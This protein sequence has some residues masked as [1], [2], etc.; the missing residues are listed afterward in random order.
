[1]QTDTRMDDA[2]GRARV[3]EE[4]LSFARALAG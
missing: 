3:A 2:A 1:L 4:T